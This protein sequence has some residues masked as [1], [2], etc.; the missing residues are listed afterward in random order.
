VSGNA[1]V[2]SLR[3]LADDLTGALDT[4]VEFVGLCGPIEVRW[5]DRLPAIAPQSLAIDSGTRECAPAKAAEIVRGLAPLL[6]DAGISYKKI[7]S[8]MRGPWSGE[9]AACFSDGFWRHCV[10]APAFPYQ[11]RRTQDG[12]QFA[13]SPDGSW[14]AAGGDIAS[15]LRAEGL[16][17]AQGS[18]AEHLAD[19]FSIFDAETEEDLDRVVAA[20]RRAPGPVI[21]C[22]SGGLARA[23]ARGHNVS[24]SRRLKKPVLG[25]FGSDHPATAAQLSACNVHWTE[26]SHRREEIPAI[27][28][29]LAETG[30]ALVSAK[31]SVG[32]SRDD[33]A[34]R[35]G[36]M[37]AGAASSLPPPGTLIVAGGETLKNL[38]TA[39]GTQS[40]LATGQVAPGVPRS[41]MQG[42]VWDGVEIVSKSG[43]FGPPALWR[44]LLIENDLMSAGSE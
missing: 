1:I 7:D 20:G 12:K 10:M 42:G 26:L 40:L 4:A 13:R 44:D 3:L 15:E 29:R 35:I 16:V 14:S 24:Q 30:V 32:A 18:P 41:L 39:L 19:G 28:R 17:A 33:A 23:L 34:R 27:E 21:W 36:E 43:A 6:R 2:P 38:C 25:L 11:G 37:F 8:L 5:A 31:L 9:L 22:G